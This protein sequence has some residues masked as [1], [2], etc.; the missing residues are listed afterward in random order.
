MPIAKLKHTRSIINERPITQPD[1]GTRSEVP[2]VLLLV[3]DTVCE[4]GDVFAM[5][6]RGRPS[7]GSETRGPSA[8]MATCC[9]N[10]VSGCS[11][12]A[13]TGEGA[14]APSALHWLDTSAPSA[15]AAFRCCC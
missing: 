15:D 12:D 13:S 4:G 6:R 10:G 3:E 7:E 5:P 14:R 8:S 9:S 1:R 2:T 11:A